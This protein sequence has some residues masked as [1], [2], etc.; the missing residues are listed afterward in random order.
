MPGMAEITIGRMARVD[1]AEAPPI[2]DHYAELAAYFDAFVD[3]AEAWERTT[4]GYHG[5]VRSIYGAIV[6]PGA[7]VL[8]IGCG[9]GDLLAS[10]EQ[11]HG[12]G[13]DVSGRMIEAARERHP[14]LEFVHAA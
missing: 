8:E 1:Q 12:V 6:P 13:V 3:R 5:L 2:A 10:L 14:E 4:D 7:R 11:S 9:R